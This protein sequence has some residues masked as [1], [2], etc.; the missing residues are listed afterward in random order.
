[1]S[2]YAA[3]LRSY[4]ADADRRA[5]EEA[6][7]SDP[8]LRLGETIRRACLS[9][10]PSKGRLVRFSHQ[11]ILQ[12]TVLAEAADILVSLEGEIA[13]SASFDALYDLVS[14]VCSALY[15]AGELYAYDVS[16]R[17]GLRIGLRPER[18]YLHRGTRA[19]ARA[20]GINVSGRKSIAMD[21]LPAGLRSLTPS[22]AE[23]AL[24]IYKS[25]FGATER[26]NADVAD[27]SGCTVRMERASRC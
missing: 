24:C 4:R 25:Y 7:W 21:E 11:C 1:M 22:E 12:R 3:I 18:V 19:G 23:D 13:Q 10:I 27:T 26:D 2:T 8:S 14:N 5:R 15:G 9:Q 6:W 17:I 16:Q 20:L